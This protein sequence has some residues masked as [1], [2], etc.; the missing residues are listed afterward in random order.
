MLAKWFIILIGVLGGVAVGIQT[1][2]TGAMG[3]RIG[4]I[5][6]GLIVHLSGAFFSAVFLILARGENIAAWRTLPWYMFASGIFG[7]IIIF[8]LSRTI[9]ELGGVVA[10]T[11]VIVGQLIAGML[12]DQ[13]GWFGVPIRPI[14]GGRI[15]AVLFLLVGGYLMVR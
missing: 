11:L 13:F 7:V 3:Q 6:S 8:T 1:P 5:A 12:V 4:G 15:V 14:D 10:I 9:P 2:I